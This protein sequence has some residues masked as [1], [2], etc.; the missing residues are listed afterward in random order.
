[1][2]SLRFIFCCLGLG[3][4]ISGCYGGPTPTQSVTPASV[5]T[6]VSTTQSTTFTVAAG[7]M[8]ATLTL[9]PSTNTDTITVTASTTAPAGAVPLSLR[10]REASQAPNIFVTIADG[11]INVNN[12][13]ST[14]QYTAG[15]FSFAPGFNQPPVVYPQSPGIQFAFN[16]PG[17]TPTFNM[18][19]C[20]TTGTPANNGYTFSNVPIQAS[21][22][23]TTYAM[24][25]DISAHC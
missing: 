21:S 3:I 23:G 25:P 15:S 10:N 2:L 12:G 4:V 13:G 5:T 16:Q 8:V 18:V 11:S 14:Q 7:T 17:Q 19:N 1:M 20:T 24:V 22:S 6:K 9:L